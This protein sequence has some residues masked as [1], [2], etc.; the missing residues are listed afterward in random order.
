M[1]IDFGH[2][3]TLISNHGWVSVNCVRVKVN[4][5]PT[6]AN[7]KNDS[8]EVGASTRMNVQSIETVVLKENALI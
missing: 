4:S 8:T 5:L 1:A 3:L 2:A 6:D 7:A